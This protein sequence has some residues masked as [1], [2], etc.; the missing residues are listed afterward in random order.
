MYCTWVEIVGDV[1]RLHHLGAQACGD[2]VHAGT[3]VGEQDKDRPSERNRASDR[4]TDR[5]RAIG[6][7][8]QSG[9]TG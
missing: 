7:N 3:C 5:P 9:K 1:V 6:R 8:R 4:E 2:I